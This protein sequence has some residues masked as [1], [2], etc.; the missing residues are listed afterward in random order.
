M[1]GGRSKNAI[2]VKKN[3]HKVEIFYPQTKAPLN[4]G[5]LYKESQMLH[6]K[7]VEIGPVVFSC[8]KILT[9]AKFLNIGGRGSGK[10]IGPK[11]LF[12]IPLPS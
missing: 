11:I 6:T 12:T 7:L 1:I 4:V 2:Y 8:E 10:K 3:K 5:G 9:S